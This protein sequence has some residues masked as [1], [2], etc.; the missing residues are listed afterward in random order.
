MLSRT[1][2]AW[3]PEN[4]MPRITLHRIFKRFS[5]SRNLKTSPATE[6]DV[7]ARPQVSVSRKAAL[8]DL[9]EA[10]TRQQEQLGALLS[11]LAELP[12]SAQRIAQAVEQ[13]AQM[14]RSLDEILTGFAHRNDDLADMFQGLVEASG[15]QAQLLAT[16]QSSISSADTMQAQLETSANRLTQSLEGINRDY[17]AQ[18]VLLNQLRDS[19][20]Q[21]NTALAALVTSQKRRLTWL[22]GGVIAALTLLAATTVWQVLS[23]RQH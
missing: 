3:M 11:A 16:I 15:K 2:A 7:Q 20:A 23:L 21:A 18:L 12:A 8:N 5:G 9:L 4:H 10:A 13:Q 1:G 22:I 17:A 19:T 6:L 14:V